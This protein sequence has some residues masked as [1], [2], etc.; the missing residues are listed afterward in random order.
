MVVTPDK[1]VTRYCSTGTQ[2]EEYLGIAATGKKVQFE[3]I[4]IYR[5]QDSLVVEQWCL[6]DDLY[7]IAQLKGGGKPRTG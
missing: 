6:G 3:E 5:I 1:V 7:C 4:S 2:H